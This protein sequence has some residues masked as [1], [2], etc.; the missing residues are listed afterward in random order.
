MSPPPPGPVPPNASRVI[1]AVLKHSFWPPGSL[2]NALPP[3]PPDQTH[4]SLLI[5]IN[6]SVRENADLDN[7]ARHGAVIEA[8]SSETLASN[9]VGR[10]IE[11]I[12][13]LTGDTDGVRWW[14][15]N[16]TVIPEEELQ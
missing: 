4:Y 13:R 8:F 3:V 15:S 10:K 2:K 7:L 11:A 5:E 6:E 14:I 9:L 12:I 1:A 16:L